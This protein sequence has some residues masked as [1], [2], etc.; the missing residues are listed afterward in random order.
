MLSFTSIKFFY[1]VCKSC[2]TK[3]ICFYFWE[4][5]EPQ[6]VHNNCISGLVVRKNYFLG[7]WG[8]AHT[9]NSGLWLHLREDAM[10]S[11]DPCSPQ[12]SSNHPGS[13]GSQARGLTLRV[14]LTNKAW[15]LTWEIK[16]EQQWWQAG[17]QFNFSMAI[18][19]GGDQFS[20]ISL[21]VLTQALDLNRW[22]FGANSKRYATTSVK[23]YSGWSLSQFWF[24]KSARSLYCL[25]EQP[26]SYEIIAPASGYSMLS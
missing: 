2:P 22:G 23:L 1:E 16:W 14:V 15:P 18:L 21:G 20:T 24:F 6:P 19:E 3:K 5:H 13:L 9:A 4:S 25:R 17:K 26:S 8:S 7:S 10:L 12:L 11:Q